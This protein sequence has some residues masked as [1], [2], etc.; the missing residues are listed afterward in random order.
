MRQATRIKITVVTNISMSIRIIIIIPTRIPTTMLTHILIQTQTQAITPI[1]SPTTILTI[2][3][4]RTPTT[5]ARNQ[6]TTLPAKISNPGKD[7][8]LI[9]TPTSTTTTTTTTIPHT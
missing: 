9:S 1:T 3:H 5:Q 4:I 7:P 6:D 8:M 2:T